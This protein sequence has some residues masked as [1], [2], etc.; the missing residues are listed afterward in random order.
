MFGCFR[1]EEIRGNDNATGLK[2]GGGIE[3]SIYSAFPYTRLHSLSIRFEYLPAWIATG[4]NSGRPVKTSPTAYTFG[5]VVCS[6]THSNLPRSS[7]VTPKFIKFK[8]EV[9]AVNEKSIF[10][11]NSK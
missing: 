11:K 6:L 9:S 5:T 4:V 3:M 2:E 7:G 1:I 8:D 10:Y